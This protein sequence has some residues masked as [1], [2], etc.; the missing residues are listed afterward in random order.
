MLL[1]ITFLITMVF[2]ASASQPGFTQATDQL[3][4]MDLQTLNQQLAEAEGDGRLPLLGELLRRNRDSALTNAAELVATAELLVDDHPNTQLRSHVHSYISWTYSRAGNAAKGLEHADLGLTLAEP[5]DLLLNANAHYMRGVALLYLSRGRD[6]AESA[7][8]ALNLFTRSKNNK[9]LADAHALLGAVHRALSEYGPALRH[10]LSARAL[11]ESLDDHNGIA[12]AENN[13]GLLY[14]ETDQHQLARKYITTALGYYREAGDEARL[15]TSYNNLGLISVELDEPE[16]AI[17][18]LSEG[19]ALE[20]TYP[21]PRN[22][23]LLLSNLGFA[24]EKLGEYSRALGYHKQVLAL[25]L[26]AKDHLGTAA[27]LG[28]MGDNHRQ[29]GDAAEAEKLYLQALVHARQANSLSQQAEFN[30]SLSEIYEQQMRPQEALGALRR[31]QALEEQ[32]N[33]EAVATELEELEDARRFAESELALNRQAQRQTLLLL[34]SAFLALL[35][36]GLFIYGRSR[37]QLLRQVQASHGELVERTQELRESERKYRSLFDDALAPIFLI[38]VESGQV[39][40]ANTPA[41]ILSGLSP[42][43]MSEAYVGQIRPKWLRRA[44]GKATALTDTEICVPE[45][46]QNA[47]GNI[48]HADIWLAPVAQRGRAGAL[49]TV[50]DTTADRREEADRIRIGKLESLGVVA[51]GIA[52]DFNNALG[53]IMGFVSLARS[54]ADRNSEIAEVL[55]DTEKSVDHCAKLTSNLMAFAKGGEP[56]KEL[57]NLAVLVADTV[58]L[59]TSGSGIHVVTEIDEDLWTAEVDADQFK[60]LISNL[61]INGMQAMKGDGKLRVKASNHT[62]REAISPEAGPGNYVLVEILDQGSGIPE[63]IRHQVLDPYFTTKAGGTGLGLASAFAIAVRHHGWLEF[64]SQEGRG[65]TFR[66]FIPG[67][68]VAVEEAAEQRAQAE[69]GSERILVMDDDE[70]IQ[71]MYQRAL[72]QLGYAVDVVDDGTAAVASYRES[73]QQ[74][75]P[76]HAVIMDLTVPGGMGGREAIDELREIDPNVVAIVASGYSNDPVMSEYKLAGFAAAL[77][78]PFSLDT[79]GGILRKVLDR[80]DPASSVPRSTISSEPANKTRH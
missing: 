80:P 65:T 40:E 39:L 14:W 48:C 16:I 4:G 47:R 52:H 76:Y 70:A 28:M 31:N 24:Y 60:Q 45:Q 2:L 54:R 55:A 12:R 5:T 13:I 67:H 11:A 30:A 71:L 26:E 63:A 66:V 56:R 64:S 74:G 53:A 42:A 49:V 32:I 69:P 18:H 59:S 61:V 78:K 22:R 35:V 38:D 57:H 62:A 58:Q 1:R 68:A 3:R 79:M 23:A 17:E 43:G 27:T 10:Q 9:K 46:W 19:L 72:T 21:S 77:P 6:A 15:V 51:G 7:H 36:G 75:S 8:R 50:R 41:L 44:M 25:R 33:L 34:I 29:L 20:Q 37:S 73:M